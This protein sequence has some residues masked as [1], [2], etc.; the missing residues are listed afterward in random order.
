MSNCAVA[1]VLEH[2]KKN[3]ENEDIKSIC[4]LAIQTADDQKEKFYTLF[5]QENYPLPVVFSFQEDGWRS[6]PLR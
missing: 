5:N 3:L 1:V 4:S 2:F 6:H